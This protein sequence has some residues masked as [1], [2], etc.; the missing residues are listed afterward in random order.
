M[1]TTYNIREM[2]ESYIAH[3]LS[4]LTDMH[5]FKINIRMR[6]NI[7]MYITFQPMYALRC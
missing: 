4:Q 2:I 5:N 3:L 6:P 7:Y 1:Y